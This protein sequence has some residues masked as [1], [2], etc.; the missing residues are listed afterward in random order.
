MAHLLVTQ[1]EEHATS[2]PLATLHQGSRNSGSG[3]NTAG[4]TDED[5]GVGH[6]QQQQ[7]QSSSPRQ[8]QGCWYTFMSYFCI[9]PKSP[10]QQQQQQ[11]QKQLS[12]GNSSSSNGWQQLPSNAPS[13]PSSS[14]VPRPLHSSAFHKCL[15]PPLS[16]SSL[17]ATRARK[18]LV[19][20]LDETLVHSSF[21]PIPNPDFV[22]SIELEGVVHRVFVRKRPGVDYFLQ[23]V[24]ERFEVVIFTASLAKYADPLL[25][26]LD[27][28][29]LINARLFRESC[30]QHYGNY[31]K[32]LTHLGRPIEHTLIVD[33]S[34]FSYMFQPENAVPCL[35]F[36][37]R[38]ALAITAADGYQGKGAHHGHI[39]VEKIT[40]QHKLLNARGQPIS[41]LGVTHYTA[42]PRHH[43]L[44]LCYAH[45]TH[46]VTPA[47]LVTLRW[48]AQPT[49]TLTTGP[50]QQVG[51]VCFHTVPKQRVRDTVGKPKTWPA[52]T[53]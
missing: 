47:H 14:S 48:N 11:Q 17:R 28:A 26:I 31:V 29:G 53:C 51:Q 39:A 43:M 32:D 46:T 23:R 33:T 19:L 6:P 7:Q 15:L 27:P 8:T 41:I 2:I 22:L 24:A 18:C 45:G 49:V 4:R 21:K 40:R 5:D 10:L 13:T 42:D 16:D 25:D 36:G 30:V 37:T 44:Q 1:V 35:A 9:T 34:P 38:V 12:S 52:L 50:Q 20:D 3:T